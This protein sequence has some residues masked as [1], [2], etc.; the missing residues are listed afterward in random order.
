MKILLFDN[1]DSFTYNL[2]HYLEDII[3]END[4]IEVQKNDQISLEDINNYDLLVL[5]PGPGVPSEAGILIDVIKEYAGK[6]PILGVCL[7]MQAIAEAFGGS[8]KNLS[9]VHHGVASNLVLAEEKTVLYENLESP[10]P[11]GRYHSWV[12]NPADFPEELVITSTDEGGEIMS[13][14][15]REYPIEAVQFHPE[16]ILTPQGK[17]MMRNFIEYIKAKK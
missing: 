17:Q 8:L 13:L 4:T 16:S 2:V 15:H 3:S 12:V 10:I 6:K 11:V 7:G 9:K 5:S 1:Y 14:K